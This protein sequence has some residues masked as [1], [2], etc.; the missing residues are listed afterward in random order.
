MVTPYD[1]DA[2]WMKAKLFINRSMDIESRRSFDE[3][4]FWSA[5]ALELLGKA[6][7]ARVSPLLIAEPT[8]EGVNILIAAGLIDGT[9]KFTSVTASTIFKRCARAFKP[10]NAADAQRYADARNEYLHGASIA[11]VALPAEGWWPRYWSLAS[12]LVTALDRTLVDLVG[13]SRSEIVESYL[14]KNTKDIIHRT[15]ALIN[16]AQQR[17]IQQRSGNLT[18]R[19]Q[20]EWSLPTELSAGLQYRDFAA[21]PAC[22]SPGMLEGED[23]S[24]A[25]YEYAPDEETGAERCWLVAKVPSE[26]F[27]CPTCRLVLDRPELV[28]QAGLPES[29][30]TEDDDFPT[31]PDYGND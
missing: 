9:S 25:T 14:A 4:A 21:C 26:Y 5:A 29:F 27:S 6:A 1:H 15:E 28:Q 7:L 17:L 19:V 2:L 31:E 12:I 18:A 13:S 8:E 3:Q 24:D 11:T 20:Q 30:E 16:R 22:E 23:S 10:F